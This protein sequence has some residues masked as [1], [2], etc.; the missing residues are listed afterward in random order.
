MADCTVLRKRSCRTRV[1]TVAQVVE[2]EGSLRYTRVIIEEQ[3]RP[4]RR[5]SYQLLRR[6]GHELP[7]RRGELQLLYVHG[8]GQGERLK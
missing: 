3:R 2:H 1:T 8:T 5:G 7:I 4:M 6:R